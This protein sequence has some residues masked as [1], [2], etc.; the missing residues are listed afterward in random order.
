MT[1]L[2]SGSLAESTMDDTTTVTTPSRRGQVE[3]NKNKG[4]IGAEESENDGEVQTCD[5]EVWETLSQSF[6]QV[7]SVLDQNRALIKQVNE[8]HQSRIPENLAKNVDLICEIS[9]NISKALSIYSDLSVNFSSIVHQRRAIMASRKNERTEGK[10]T[11]SDHLE[12]Q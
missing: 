6:R 7:Q 9:S 4:L 3:T 2:E 8:N 5:V 12:F 11:W 1:R 10:E